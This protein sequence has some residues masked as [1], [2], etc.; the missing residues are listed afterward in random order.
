MKLND[1]KNKQKYFAYINS[2]KE[3]IEI[4]SS[5]GAFLSIAKYFFEN[6]KTVI[7]GAETIY[8]EKINVKHTRATSFEECKKFAGSKYVKSAISYIYIYIYEDYEKYDKLVFTGLPCQIYAIKQFI[9]KNNY[10]INKFFFID[11]ICHG[12]GNKKF[13]QSYIDFL[14]QKYKSKIKK[15][16]FR[17]KPLGWKGYPYYAEFENGK[18]LKN[19]FILRNYPILYTKGYIIQKNCF[20]C[21]FAN[22]D[23]LSDI[24]LGDFWGVNEKEFETSKGISLIISNTEESKKIVNELHKYGKIKEISKEQAIKGQGNLQGMHSK[25]PKD[26]DKFWDDFENVSFK[27]LLKKYGGLNFKYFIRYYVKKI[28]VKLRIKKV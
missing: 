23:R 8:D 6:F 25:I 16:S 2:D 13:F 7:Y 24:T 5:G 22:L 1:C 27:N 12:V 4:S 17:F 21:P 10:D 3:D 28:L 9:K 15:F 26:Y 11:L 20:N 19:T 14:E 18:K